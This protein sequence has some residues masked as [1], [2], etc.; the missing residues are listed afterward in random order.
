MTLLGQ[1]KNISLS[2]H[3]AFKKVLFVGNGVSVMKILEMLL[4]SVCILIAYVIRFL[5][6]LFVLLAK[7]AVVLLFVGV[8]VGIANE[9]SALPLFWQSLCLKS[10]IFLGT[11]SFVFTMTLAVRKPDKFSKIFK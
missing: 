3:Y 2:E 7:I 10:A 4:V 6:W 5:D 11:L 9:V 1:R 8:F